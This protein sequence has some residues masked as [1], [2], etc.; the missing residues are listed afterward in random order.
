MW[1]RPA[2][3]VLGYVIWGAG[4]GSWMYPGKLKGIRSMGTQVG[5]CGR[6]DSVLLPSWSLYPGSKRN[7]G[8]HGIRECL[9]IR[10]LPILCLRSSLDMGDLDRWKEGMGEHEHPSAILLLA[11]S[12][13]NSLWGVCYPL[14][15]LGS[16]K[17]SSDPA[18]LSCFNPPLSVG[19]FGIK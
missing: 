8:M 7:Q 10:G 3:C 6:D 11:K 14:P 1:S 15:S 19:M 9:W 16:G 2:G 5:L 13:Y 4:G 18:F 12:Q 17:T